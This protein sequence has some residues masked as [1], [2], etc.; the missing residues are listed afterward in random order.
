VANAFGAVVSGGIETIGVY[1]LRWDEPQD[2]EAIKPEIESWG[3]VTAV[4]DSTVDELGADAIPPGDWSDDGPQATWPFTLTRATEAWNSTTGSNVGVGIV[5]V[6]Q[7][8][9]GHEDLN[10]VDKLGSNDVAL[11]ATHV[12][13]IACAKANGIGVVGF[14]WGCPITTSGWGD[15][16]DKAV[17]AAATEVA[18]QPG[19]QVINMSL[20][21]SPTN[22]GCASS[23]F[24]NAALAQ[25]SN[26]KAA[27]RQLFRSAV[28]RDIVWT[29]SAGNDCA[30]GVPSAWGLNSDLG[31][32]VAVAA[33]NSNG[34]L[35]SFSDFGEGVEV[36]APGGVSVSPIG[37]GTVGIWSTTVES[38]YIFFH[39]GS[40]AATHNGEP[41]AGTSMSAPAVAGIAALVR[42]AHPDY[43]AS[44]AAGCIVGTAGENTPVVASRSSL[45]AGFNAQFSYPSNSLSV[46]DAE[47]AVKC[48]ELSFDGSP[49]TGPPPATLGPYTMTPFAPDPRPEGESVSSLADPAGTIGF[50]PAVTHLVTPSSW[51]TWSHGYSGDVYFTET[52]STVTMTLPAGTK[53]F[54]FYAEPNTFDSFTVEAI[55]QD[56]T[57]S[58]PVDIEGE[59]GARYFGFYGTAAQTV[60]KIKVTASDPAG[61]AVGEFEIAH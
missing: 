32:V 36:A 39:C 10:V 17:L 38:C 26:Y 20:G 42:A 61:F 46:V 14:A 1:E 44:R 43:G 51:A 11:H 52:E 6:G 47:A 55:A 49:G 13:G 57:S 54:A 4:S 25:A 21:I 15:G 50:S 48:D 56:G 22:G 18:E 30:P 12:A 7:A 27:F 33:V 9:A 8:Y 24:Q 59:E 37:D 40:Y 35:A 53:A 23:A 31:N 16:S 58:E 2:L 5:D 60:A 45:P 28:G 19:V 29:V 34:Q 3:G 41:I